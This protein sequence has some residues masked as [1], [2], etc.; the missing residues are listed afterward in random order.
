MPGSERAVKGKLTCLEFDY[1]KASDRNSPNK[2]RWTAF[3]SGWDTLT[4]ALVIVKGRQHVALAALVQCA[5]HALPLPLLR[6]LLLLVQ[7]RQRA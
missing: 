5:R 1:E 4:S 3:A 6:L 2:S 7:Q